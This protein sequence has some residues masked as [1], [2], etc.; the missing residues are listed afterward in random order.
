ML[1]AIDCP[2]LLKN[3]ATTGKV[4]SGPIGQDKCTAKGGHLCRFA[5]VFQ[6]TAQRHRIC[7][8][9]PASCFIVVK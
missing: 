6:F 7:C 1:S 2:P 9:L 3:I 4:V 5:D 8:G